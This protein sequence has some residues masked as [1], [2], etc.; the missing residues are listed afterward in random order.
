MML[1]LLPLPRLR[2]AMAPKGRRKTPARGHRL[3]FFIRVRL[4][5]SSGASRVGGDWESARRSRELQPRAF[6]YLY[7]IAHSESIVVNGDN[8]LH[9]GHH[10]AYGSFAMLAARGE[11]VGQLLFPESDRQ[12]SSGP[13][14]AM[15]QLQ[16]FERAPATFACGFPLLKL[17]KSQA[18]VVRSRIY[19]STSN[20]YRRT[21]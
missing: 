6:L 19:R 7:K 18:P 12:S 16:R 4:H 2:T 9:T 10:V 20:S 14:V 21:L 1:V 17:T 3:G 8:F 11:V 5:T 13:H 15:G